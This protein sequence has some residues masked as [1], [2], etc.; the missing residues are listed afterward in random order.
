MLFEIIRKYSEE[1]A[2]VMDKDII[3]R[4]VGLDINSIDQFAIT[5]QGN[6]VIVTKN[7]EAKYVSGTGFCARMNSSVISDILYNIIS[8]ITKNAHECGDPNSDYMKGRLA[9]SNEDI[10]IVRSY[11]DDDDEIFD[12][13][14]EE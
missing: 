12:D 2:T 9:S 11:I 10:K 14:E 4:E 13:E 8:D 5:E 7:G 3:A 6:L 1:S